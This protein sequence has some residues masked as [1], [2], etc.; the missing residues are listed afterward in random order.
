MLAV[1]LKVDATISAIKMQI[2]MLI[3]LIEEINL[4]N[5][6]LSYLPRSDPDI[7]PKVG[8][9]QKKTTLSSVAVLL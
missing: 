9:S 2:H 3:N 8:L 7:I 5:T 6:V 4:V 1:R